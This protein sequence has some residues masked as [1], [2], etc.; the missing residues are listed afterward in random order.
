[1]LWALA[2]ATV[3]PILGALYSLYLTGSLRGADLSERGRGE[4]RFA[5][6]IDAVVL[7]GALYLL[8]FRY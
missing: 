1:V 6:I 8:A 3:L 7:G 2:G 4:R 5:M